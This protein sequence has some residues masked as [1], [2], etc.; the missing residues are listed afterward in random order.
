LN[1]HITANDRLPEQACLFCHESMPG[2][3]FG[4]WQP[5]PVELRPSLDAV[6]KGCHWVLPHPGDVFT[7]D[8][9]F[10]SHLAVPSADVL[11]TINETVENG[12][13]QLPLDPVTG[14]I[15]CTTCHNPHHAQ[16]EG[17]PKLELSVHE[18]KLRTANTCRACHDM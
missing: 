8:S 11:R 14:E 2:I 5:T 18:H 7:P 6:C 4:E 12:D 16:V 17:L 1:P 13:T 9:R 15:H 10:W 3:S